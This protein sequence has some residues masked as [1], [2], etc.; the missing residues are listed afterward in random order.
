MSQA[1]QRSALAGALTGT[2]V[3]L[4]YIAHAAASTGPAGLTPQD[5]APVFLS[6]CATGAIVGGTCAWLLMRRQ[7]R[8]GDAV[9]ASEEAAA[10]RG[11]HAAHAESVAEDVDDARPG[12]HFRNAAWE[13]AGAIRV[14]SVEDS[15]V[16]RMP[17]DAFTAQ[18][19][20]HAPAS[21]HMRADDMRADA[22]AKAV[23]KADVPAKGSA[24]AKADSEAEPELITDTN[25]YAVVAESYV[26][27]LTF[28]ERMA[29]RAKGVAA[30]LQDRLGS[31]NMMD[32]VPVI[33]RADGTTG[34]VG[35]AWWDAAVGDS[36]R[37]DGIE[38]DFLDDTASHEVEQG[39]LVQRSIPEASMPTQAAASPSANPGRK[40]IGARV[41]QVDEGVFPE[42]REVEDLGASEDAFA[43]ALKA[44]DERISE[45]EPIAFD[46]G[47]GG[48][49]TIDEPDG[50]EG[51]TRF[52][53]FRMPAGH[54]EVVDTDSYVDYL[55][56]DEFSHNPSTAARRSSRDFLKV[57]EGGS[58]EMPV[59]GKDSRKQGKGP[60]RPSHFAEA[61]EA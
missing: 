28:R 39:P 46:D 17:E 13:H 61:Q 51:S 29:T 12:K 35:T 45:Q 20:A 9:R 26:R 40:E 42:R 16:L 55:I 31:G 19:P 60:H 10:S 4:P 23:A 38:S 57:I 3:T 49:E 56:G 53:P 54:P 2:L 48:S 8:S 52:I 24:A 11:A 27:R 18:A 47:I 59:T 41:A 33:R 58:Q 5:L 25:D 43:A 21:G 14:Q 7:G 15:Q 34:D 22:P 36:I 44:L 1:A 32:G 50:L 30:V 6:G 37:R